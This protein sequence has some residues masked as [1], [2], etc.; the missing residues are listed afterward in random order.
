MKLTLKSIVFLFSIFLTGAAAH[1][2]T[3]EEILARMMERNAWQDRA[4]L[5]YRAQ[6]KFYAA[7]QRFKTDS[8][9][10]VQTTYRRPDQM[11]ST[12][13]KHEGSSLIRSRV[14][15]KI[16]EA[17]AETRSKKDKQQVD[18]VPANYDFKLAGTAECEGRPCFHLAISPKR[19]DKYSLEGE[20]WL[21][22]QDYSIVRIYGAPARKPSFWT[23]KTEI[24]RRYKKIDGIWLPYRMDSSSDIMVAG[25]SVL[26]IEYTY[27]SV[28]TQ[29]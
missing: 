23:R 13:T 14:F 7:N 6:R 22:A 2:Q 11:Q 9:M 29:Q 21:D 12:V 24:D 15:D 3:L 26:S 18:I 28:Q 8:T 4:L 19:K 1:A 20:I 27:D 16:L 25:H 5:E 17:E 10:H